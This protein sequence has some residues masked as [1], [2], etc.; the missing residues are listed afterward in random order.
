[1]KSKMNDKNIV[2]SDWVQ[3]TLHVPNLAEKRPWHKHI[4]WIDQL[5]AT[6]NL[7]PI[8]GGT[9]AEEIK[10]IT[11][12]TTNYKASEFLRKF[13]TFIY[14][15]D[16]FDDKD[17]I[18]FLNELETAA[19]DTSGNVI[20]SII[21]RLDNINK[22]KILANLVKAKG[23]KRISIE[24]FFRLES[25]LER[26][27]YVDLKQLILYQ[28]EYY[29][30]SGDTELLYATGVLRSTVYHQD[31]DKYILSPLGVN[32]LKYG[33]RMSAN[34]PKI[35][36]TSTGV[37][38]EEIGEVPDVKRVKDIVKHTIEEQHYTESDQAMFD[39]DVARGK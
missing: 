31:G 11:E 30:E 23:E 18:A 17:R 35:K 21:D 39:Y 9:I 33:L 6:V 4:N 10:T 25:V 38:W 3:K 27:P 2:L 16:H 26:I 14:E 28:T 36:G 15:L 19:E 20:L 7:I 22:Q 37:K 8:I 1:M 32:L 13:I 12:V 34:P 5:C 29:D 24:E